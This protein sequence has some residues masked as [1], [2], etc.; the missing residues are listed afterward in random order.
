[1]NDVRRV[2]LLAAALWVSLH[3][4][5]ALLFAEE[6]RSPVMLGIAMALAVV[7]A[8][9]SL[10][11]LLS[12]AP[13]AIDRR[14]GAA[15]VLATT[16]MVLCVH[17]YL[18]PRGLA[19]YA[20]W[21]MGEVGVLIAT[22]VLRECLSCAVATTA[23][24]VVSNAVA[25]AMVRPEESS[26]GLVQALFLS[27][28]PLTWLLG[29]LGISTVLR[30]G[31]LL[32]EEYVRRGF[33]FADEERLRQAVSTA[34]A[35]RRLELRTR[36]EPL[37]RRVEAEGATSRLRAEARLAAEDLRDSLKARSLLT[38]PLRDHVA[39]ARARGV[40]VTLSSAPTGGQDADAVL[41]D[42]TR[43]LLELVLAEADLGSTV[44]CRT[45]RRPPVSVLLLRAP[46]WRETERVRRV[47]EGALAAAPD[48][49]LH[50]LLE[51]YDGEL[52][53]ELRQDG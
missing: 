48:D 28:P 33:T 13:T 4:T 10:A 8:V 52:L 40:R 11:P 39:A 9:A 32:R 23:V 35:T 46:T 34:D 51:E 19:A 31:A 36:V 42:R 14:R 12:E 21:P 22:L 43:S 25:I 24:V 27:V 17:P 6:H 53:I 47:L 44:S 26:I 16:A 5:E 50:A 49:G 30:R 15:L 45:T 38:A 3:L 18:T 29:S 7:I 2:T 41:L 20:N 1:M 37:L